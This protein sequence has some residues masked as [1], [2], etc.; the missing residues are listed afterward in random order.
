MKGLQFLGNR[1]EDAANAF[2]DVLKYSDQS[3]DYPDFKDIEPWPDEIVNM[4]YNLEERQILRTKCNYV[5]SAIRFKEISEL[6]LGI[7]LVEMRHLDKISDFIQLADPYEDYSVININPTIE[8]GSTWEQALKIAWDSEIETIGYY[9]KIQKAIAQ[10]N[11]RPDYDDVNYF[12]E[13]LIADEEHHIK[14]LKEALG[15]DKG[16]KG[17][18]SNMS[19]VAI[20]YKESRDNY[21]SGNSY[22]WCPCCGKCYILS[23]EEVVNAIDNDLSVYAECPCCGNSFYIETEDEQDN[24]SEW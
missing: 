8:I 7:G 6:M 23:E 4:F 3:V 10:Y 20:I 13:K 16:T 9:K 21:I 19:Q 22:T 2:I 1:V 24:Y 17:V 14:L 11:E 5:Y 12:L 15:V 18:T